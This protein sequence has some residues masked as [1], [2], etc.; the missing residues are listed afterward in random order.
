MP[1]LSKKITLKALESVQDGQILWDT[2]LRGFGVRGRGTG[3]YYVLKTRVHGQ[4]RW[5]TIGKQGSPWTPETARKKVLQLLGEIA[6]GND[7]AEVREDLKRRMSVADLCDLYLKEGCSEKKPSTLATDKGRIERHI[8]PLLGRKDA[9]T[10]KKREIE[11]FMRDVGDGKTA[12]DVKTGTRGRAIVEG[13][14]GTATRTI[15]LLGGIFSFAMDRQI[16]MENPVRGIKRFKDKRV[17]RFLSEDELSSLG[18]ALAALESEGSITPHAAAAIRLLLF[19]GARRGEILSLRWEWVDFERG[20]AFLPDS[21]T[22]RKPLYLSAPA[23]DVLANLPRLEGNPHVICGETQAKPLAD[24]KRPWAKACSRAGIVNLRIHDLRHNF[25][26]TGAMGGLSLPMI[27]K[28]LGH[29]R[30]ETTARY[31]HLADDPV[32]SA[33]ERIASRIAQSLQRPIETL[34]TVRGGRS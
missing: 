5:F 22:G 8:K 34:G 27:G 23:L 16:V 14:K 33:N 31:S 2:E 9:R 12:A 11:Q 15:G 24:L 13:G 20:F 10:L 17:E 18:A 30:T 21:K 29:L 4:Q 7:P 1:S 32:R 3:L 25:A 28:L 19:T 26:S 6:E